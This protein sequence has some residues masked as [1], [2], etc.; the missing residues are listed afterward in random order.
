MNTEHPL[1]TR[2]PRASGP[3]HSRWLVRSCQNFVS[4]WQGRCKPHFSFEL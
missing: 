2:Q 4:N 3:K 1:G